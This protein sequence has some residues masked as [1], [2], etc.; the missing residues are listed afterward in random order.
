MPVA[1]PRLC[2][3]HN[4]PFEG[5]RCPQCQ[6]FWQKQNRERDTRPS[7]H[8]R[9]YTSN[10]LKVRTMKLAQNPLCERCEA[11][12]I[13][14]PATLVHHKDRISRNNRPQNLESLCPRCHATEHAGELWGRSNPLK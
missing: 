3:R 2:A 6:E 13:L 14:L 11:A 12:G 5:R 9:G 10:W 4:L 1:P 8:K 7:A